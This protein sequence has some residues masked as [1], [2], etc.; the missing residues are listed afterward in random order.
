[1]NERKRVLV[2]GSFDIIHP[3]HIFLINEAAKMG[4]VYI[5]VARDST[6]K[7]YKGQVPIVPEDQRLEV[8]KALKNVQDA[9]LGNKGKNFMNRALSLNPDIIL[10]G[11]NQR[12]SIENLNSLLKEFKAEHIQVKRLEKFY[13][14]FELN[15]STAIKQKIIKDFQQ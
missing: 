12:I 7:T 5:I 11:P 1:M 8:V 9:I 4:D 14:K 6:I 15:S 3:G 10:L 13:D 2:T